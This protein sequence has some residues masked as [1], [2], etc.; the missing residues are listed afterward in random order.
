[1]PTA[2]LLSSP[3]DDHWLPDGRP[4]ELDADLVVDLGVR[5]PELHSWAL[6]AGRRPEDGTDWVVSSSHRGHTILRAPKGSRH[7]GSSIPSC[8][9]TKANPIL[10]ILGWQERWKGIAT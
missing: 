3:I 2:R 1:M 9:T 4:R 8:S 7:N 5:I 6:F 10:R